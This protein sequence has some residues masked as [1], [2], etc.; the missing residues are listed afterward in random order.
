MK[1]PEEQ[2][3]KTI[4]ESFVDSMPCEAY[5]RSSR[6]TKI[7]AALFVKDL[8]RMGSYEEWHEYLSGYGIILVRARAEQHYKEPWYR[9]SEGRFLV[10][11]N[12]AETDK[13][14]LMLV[15]VK[16]I[17]KMIVLGI[18]AKD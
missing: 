18:L 12:P 17:E 4:M 13:D 2:K 7:L 15:P 16:T 3:P 6:F 9:W 10:V 1:F 14:E 8:A 11:K 5:E